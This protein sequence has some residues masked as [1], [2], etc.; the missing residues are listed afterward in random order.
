MKANWTSVWLLLLLP[1]LAVSAYLLWQS[2]SARASDVPGRKVLY[3]QDS[4]HPWV[5]SDQ[6]GKCTI[7]GMD[8]T[9]ILE[10]EKSF[11]LSNSVVVLR[12]NMITVLNVQT[13]AVQRRPLVRS[14]RVAGT[15]EA[16]EGRKAVLAAPARGRIEDMAVEYAGVEV[17]KGQSLISFF[18]PDL[19]ALRRIQLVAN[20]TTQGSN[21]AVGSDRYTAALVAPLSGVVLERNVYSGQYVAEGDRLLTIADASVL[22][23]RFDVYERQLPWFEVGQTIAVETPGVPGKLFPAVISFVEPTVNEATRTIKVRAEVSNPVMEINGHKRRLLKYGMYAEGQ[24]RAQVP[25]AVAVPRAA[26]LFPG[27]EAYAYVERG[28]GAYER[29]RVKLGRQGD[30]LWEVLQGLTE[31]ERVVT[32]GNVLMDAQAQFNQPAGAGEPATE[33]MASP[34]PAAA[35]GVMAGPMSHCTASVSVAAETPAA[36]EKRPSPPEQMPAPVP[37][38]PANEPM[39]GDTTQLG[40][41]RRAQAMRAIA[42]Q[43]VVEQ[44]TMWPTLAKGGGSDVGNGTPVGA[45]QG[46]APAA[47]MAE[48]GGLP[49]AGTTGNAGATGAQVKGADPGLVSPT[50][51]QQIEALVREAGAISAALAADDLTQFNQHAA[52]LPAALGPVRK[53]LAAAHHW[54][55][56]LAPMEE[57]GKAEAAKDLAQAR[58]RFLPFSTAVVEWAKRLRKE[59]PGLPALKIYHCPMAPKPGLWIQVSGPLANPFYGKKMLRC[60]EPVEADPPTPASAN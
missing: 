21:A 32:S 58:A 47:G 34:P 9:A 50:Q 13:E 25:E 1:I 53:E 24:V 36:A 31:G 37:S 29:R 27:E 17:E 18:S 14:L 8:L 52:Q 30:E 40:L 35:E 5:K 42:S 20:F 59:A 16:N 19:V 48:K 55:K 12:S 43:G 22:W 60:G 6:P 51:C 26:I 54:E 3:Y 45:S 57:L 11:G 4:M 49:Q 15:L 7:C 2:S 39:P 38:A 46:T 23:F 10:G 28:D 56:L 44:M 33:E 41:A